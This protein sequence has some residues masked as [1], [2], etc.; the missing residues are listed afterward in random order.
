MKK[1]LFA[2][3]VAAT[4]LAAVQP[5]LGG[6]WIAKNPLPNSTENMACVRLG[7]EIHVLGGSY[8]DGMTNWYYDQN[9][10]Y[11]PDGDT[12]GG[13]P[14]SAA[15]VMNAK[16]SGLCAAALRDSFIYVFGGTDSAGYYQSSVEKYYWYG[17]YWQTLSSQM[18]TERWFSQAV[19]CN[20]Y[21]YVMGGENGSG[22]KK[23]MERLN[24]VTDNIITMAPMDIPRKSFFAASINGKIYVIG[25]FSTSSYVS[26][27]EEYD[28]LNGPL[29]T[30]T[31]RTPMPDAR[32]MMAGAVLDNKIIIFGGIDTLGNYLAE[33]WVYDPATDS[34]DTLS[35]N[36]NTPRI[37]LGGA[38]CNGRLY[39]FGGHDVMYTGQNLVEEFVATGPQ[40]TWISPYDGE[41]G[42]STTAQL[43]VGFNTVMDTM[44]GMMYTCSP[45]P[46]GWSVHW[47]MS[48][49]TAFFDHAP[50]AGGTSHTFQITSAFDASF[51][52]LLAGAVPNPWTFTTLSGDPYEPNNDAASA[53]LIS[54]GD[55]LTGAAI[56]PDADYD[57][58]K[59][60]GNLG[61]Y[62]QITCYAQGTL[63]GSTLDSYIHLYNPGQSEIAVNDDWS[64]PMYG[65]SSRLSFTLTQTGEHYIRVHKYGFKGKPPVPGSKGASDS[66]NI[67]IFDQLT[68]VRD[69]S[70]GIPAIVRN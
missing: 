28:P 37:Y 67:A 47:S 16:R 41:S 35:G 6:Y 68:T 5:A 51:Q 2:L 46:G 65:R 18:S 43:V 39:A 8:W 3:L 21:I 26:S 34:W 38:A 36:M 30:W 56:D 14:W 33:P 40:I 13:N 25:G 29:G 70:A 62:V 66:F 64:Y 24:P 1:I 63:P 58:F 45:D 42:V 55:S 32:A 59:F 69:H 53:R 23:I 11:Q 52:P 50:F 31:Y 54:N 17:N 15:M 4:T 7:T 19:E 48:G 61:E 27:V 49:D 20:D 60:T 9:L 12:S 44:G 10:V 22:V 57:W